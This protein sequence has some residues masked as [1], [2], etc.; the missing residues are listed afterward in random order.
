MADSFGAFTTLL[1]NAIAGGI[2]AAADQIKNIVQN[3]VDGYYGEYSPK[4]YIRTYQFL[5]SPKRTAVSSG[6]GGAECEIFID[7]AAM[8][9]EHVSGQ[10][11]ANWANGGVH[12]GLDVGGA[13]FWDNALEQIESQDI[14]GSLFLSYLKGMGFGVSGA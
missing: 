3:N 2:D 9:Y 8:G 14:M 13:P 6:G 7:T 12:G 4:E 10:Q 5:N 1:Q 11:V